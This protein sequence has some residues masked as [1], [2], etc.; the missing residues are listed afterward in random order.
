MN[1]N[2][3]RFILLNKTKKFI[4]NCDN[5]IINLP[6][7]ENSLRNNFKNELYT[8]LK[9]LMYYKDNYSIN[10]KSKYLMEYI[11]NIDMIDYYLEE[12]IN[13]KNI[14]EKELKK[15]LKLLSELRSICLGIYKSIGIK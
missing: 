2:N 13:K 10:I 6:N 8:L 1:S 12:C 3:E 4:N 7:K 15:T 14:S 11:I 5:I 9:N